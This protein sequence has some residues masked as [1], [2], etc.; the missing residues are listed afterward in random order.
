MREFYEQRINELETVN[1][2]ARE[3]SE[4]GLVDKDNLLKSALDV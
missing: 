1:G 3:Q 4:N 2:K